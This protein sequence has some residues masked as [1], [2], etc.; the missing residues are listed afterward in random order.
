MKPFIQK[1][2]DQLSFQ[3]DQVSGELP[4]L[5][6]YKTAL[7]IIEEAI[8]SVKDFM[9]T[10]D[11]A[12]REEEIYFYKEA[13]PHLLQIEIYYE[14][15][16]DL[17]VERA[18][19]SRGDYHHHVEEEIREVDRFFF[20]NKF[21]YTYYL[22]G[23]TYLDIPYYT[24]NG[25]GWVLV[26]DEHFCTSNS[27]LLAQILANQQ[28]RERLHV[29][30]DLLLGGDEGKTTGNIP[31]GKIEF[32]GTDADLAE[33]VPPLHRLKLI[34]INGKEATQDQLLELLDIFF[35][36]NVKANFSAIDNKNRA[37]KKSL[38]PFLLRL[39]DAFHERSK[40]LLK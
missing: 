23:H 1:I 36:R 28:Y 37:R 34:R 16:Y 25:H 17:A 7:S 12:D 26:Y 32:M 8:H 29:E 21:A 3:L 2:K 5:Q 31:D 22:K 24:R 33:I 30:L 4:P 9:Q 10:Y 14:K 20:K 39:I 11:F 35:H 15:L 27:Y 40:E 19:L 13:I 38:T 6:Y 18:S